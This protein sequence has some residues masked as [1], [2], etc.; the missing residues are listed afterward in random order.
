MLAQPCLAERSSLLEICADA[1]CDIPKPRDLALEEAAAAL[2]SPGLVGIVQKRLSVVADHVAGTVD[3][4][5]RVVILVRRRPCLGNVHLLGISDDH[6]AVMAEGRALRPQ[7][8]DARARLFETGSNVLQRL[9]VVACKA[10]LVL[11]GAWL[12]TMRETHQ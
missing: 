10:V 7:G 8:R 5:G 6:G 12:E 2:Q 11:C 1:Q 9:E 3:D 4:E